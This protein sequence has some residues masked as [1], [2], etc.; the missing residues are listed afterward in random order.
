MTPLEIRDARDS[1]FESILRLNDVE[2]QQTSQMDLERL[3]TLDHLSAYHKVAVLGG[4]VAGFIIAIRAGV[5]YEN[6]N[7]AWFTSRLDD[8]LYVD[9]I[10]VGSDFSGR[11]IGSRLYQDI[12]AYAKAQGIS[13]ITCEYN[14]D[15]PNLASRAF[16]DKFGFRELGTQWVA[17]GTK[18]VSLQAAAT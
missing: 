11:K 9:R 4:R 6:D 18:L 15:P 14:I 8:F 3:R 12:F 10:V 2:V 1:D 13:N 16:H 5:P 17:G 7:F